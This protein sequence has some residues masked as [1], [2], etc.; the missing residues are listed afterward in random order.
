MASAIRFGPA[1]LC[2]VAGLGCAAFLV[3]MAGEASPVPDFVCNVTLHPALQRDG[4]LL[5]QGIYHM[6]DRVGL[7]GYAEPG[8]QLPQVPSASGIRFSDGA[9]SFSARG[10]SGFLELADGTRFACTANAG[11]SGWLDNDPGHR[12]RVARSLL[13]S[14][15]RAGDSPKARQI[16]QIRE[17]EAI[18]ILSETGSFHDG[19]QWVKVRYGDGPQGPKEGYVWGGTICTVDGPEISGV[20]DGCESL[21]EP[22]N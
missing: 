10:K 1:A 8:E 11:G 22:E 5:G 20:H 3:P 13:G 14:I 9:I 19:W 17:G 16:V 15:L 18:E 7:I 2:G 21:T 6:G 4:Y 12:P